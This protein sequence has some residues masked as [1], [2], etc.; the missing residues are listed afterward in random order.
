MDKTTYEKLK[1]E[2]IAKYL[3]KYDGSDAEVICE[4]TETLSDVVDAQTANMDDESIL[5]QFQ[6]LSELADK[7]DVFDVDEDE[8]EDDIDVWEFFGAEFVIAN[9][10][11]LKE[12]KYAFLINIQDPNDFLIRKYVVED[13][14]TALPS[15]QILDSDTE[16][17]LALSYFQK[18]YLEIG[19][20]S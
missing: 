19:G 20:Q 14:D 1:K 16:Y 17:E 11:T 2:Y 7:M 15:L 4:I 13:S 10:V 5:M 3:E 18:K 8:D 12:V 6:L 9:E